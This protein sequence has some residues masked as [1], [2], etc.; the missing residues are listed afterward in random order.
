M[1]GSDGLGLLL[2]HRWKLAAIVVFSIIVVLVGYIAAPLADGVMLGIVLAYVGRPLRRWM[3]KKPIIGRFASILTTALVVLPMVVIVTLGFAEIARWVVVLVEH[4]QDVGM[5]ISSALAQLN[6]P[7]WAYIQLVHWSQS[8]IATPLE[9]LVSLLQKIPIATYAWKIG[10]L[11]LNMVISLVVC[12]FLLADGDKLSST[13]MVLVPREYVDVFQRYLIRLDS[14]LR[15]IF[16]GTIYTA[17]IVSMLSV[18]VFSYFHIPSVLAFSLLVFIAALVPIFSGAMII[19]PLAIYRYVEFGLADAVIFLVVSVLCIYAPA[20]LV[21][22]PYIVSSETKIHPLLLLIAFIG[23]GLAGGIAGFFFAPIL[24]GALV[25][26]YE[27]YAERIREQDE[28]T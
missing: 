14:I 15:G 3:L 20:E 8:L 24:V 9:S 5:Y 10:M 19:G 16:M 1:D 26:A 25:A 22:R 7:D 13:M 11:I 18:V 2:R 12:Y 23:G 4:S 27:L 6:L 28:R 21:I 17:I